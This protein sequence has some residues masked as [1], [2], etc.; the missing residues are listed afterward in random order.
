MLLPRDFTVLLSL[1]PYCLYCLEIAFLFF[2]PLWYFYYFFK[3]HSTWSFY[4]LSIGIVQIV[5]FL[6]DLVY[7]V[8][9]EN[10]WIFLTD[11]IEI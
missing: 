1:L 2:L 7:N 6:N 8:K 5:F 3:I 4:K 9:V 10:K 11:K